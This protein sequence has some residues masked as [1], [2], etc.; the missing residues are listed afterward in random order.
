M[1]L[2]A[3]ED[4]DN[5]PTSTDRQPPLHRRLSQRAP[6]ESYE[7]SATAAANS[8]FT[9]AGQRVHQGA[10]SASAS[11]LVFRECGVAYKAAAATIC[12]KQRMYCCGTYG[13]E[14]RPLLFRLNQA[15][16][17]RLGSLVAVGAATAAAASAFTAKRGTSFL[18][19]LRLS[20]LSL[21]VSANGPQQVAPG[22]Q[23]DQLRGQ[24]SNR[25]R[26]IPGH[27]KQTLQRLGKKQRKD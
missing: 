1:A 27:L 14:Q 26:A 23:R 15:A 22:R 20:K 6:F 4:G 16:F 17:R 5:G 9:A 24:P 8:T 18:R 10:A 12:G 21:A 7:G 11:K 19:Q 3:R 13:F 25:L 2:G